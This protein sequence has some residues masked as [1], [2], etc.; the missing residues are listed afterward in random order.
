MNR[1]IFHIDIDRFYASVEEIFEKKI[2][3]LPMVVTNKHNKSVILTSNSLARKLGIKAGMKLYEAKKICNNLYISEPKYYLY[4]TFSKKFFAL[5]KENITSNIEVVSIDECFIDV[6]DILEKYHNSYDVLAMKII[7][8]VK[9]E[10]D[11]DVTIGISDTKFLAKVAGNEKHENKFLKLFKKDVK[12]KIW[13][14]NIGDIHMVGESMKLFLLSKNINTVKEFMEYNDRDYLVQKLG[15]TYLNLYNN[16]NGNGDDVINIDM[17]MPKSISVDHTFSVGVDDKQIIINK[18]YLLSEQISKRLLSKNLV[19]STFVIKY[20]KE[21]KKNITKT[22]AIKSYINTKEEI[23]TI[24]LD[25]F[26]ETWDF[27]EIRLLSVSAKKLKKSIS[28]KKNEQINLF[29]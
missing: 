1:I 10:L 8:L 7:E 17:N 22:K 15:L 20:Q 19:A 16:L 9:S 27:F 2:S 6:T 24:F 13:N 14:K 11:I 26:L 3:L 18:I 29:K 21:Y 4:K 23:V 28:Y 12:N 25:L 5:L